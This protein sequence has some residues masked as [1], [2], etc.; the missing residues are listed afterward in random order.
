[1]FSWLEH[2]G[3]KNQSYRLSPWKDDGQDILDFFKPGRL[4]VSTAYVRSMVLGFR[5]FSVSEKPLC[6]TR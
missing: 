5:Y 2:D 3:G 4:P 6:L 1:L